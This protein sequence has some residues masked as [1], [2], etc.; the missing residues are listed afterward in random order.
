MGVAQGELTPQQADTLGEL[1]GG[2]REG[3]QDTCPMA[4]HTTAK[5][6]PHLTFLQK[7]ME[8]QRVIWD[9]NPHGSHV[10]AL[11]PYIR[12]N[13]LGNAIT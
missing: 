13:D 8:T 9:A 1:E 7:D 12:A 3:E 6:H 2:R 11:Q 5:A 10:K 4:S